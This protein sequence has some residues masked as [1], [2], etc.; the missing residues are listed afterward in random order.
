MKRETIFCELTKC[1]SEFG[2][3]PFD[4]FRLLKPNSGEQLD[5]DL[6]NTS[7]MS[8]KSDNWHSLDL[9]GYVLWATSDNADLLWWNGSFVISMNPRAREY[10]F[11]NLNPNMFLKQLQDGLKLHVYPDDLLDVIDNNKVMKL[12][13]IVKQFDKFED[14]AI[15]CISDTQRTINAKSEMFVCTNL[16]KLDEPIIPDGF[17]ELMPL[18]LLG[19]IINGIRQLDNPQDFDELIDRLILYFKNDA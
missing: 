2:D 7:W 15:L 3:R 11:V 19:N 18:W 16:D 8:V 1:H 10:A 14:D 5:F 13:E 4:F 9:S 6:E 17:T 12:P